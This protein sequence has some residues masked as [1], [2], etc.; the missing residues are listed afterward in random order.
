MF[1]NGTN[2]LLTKDET[3]TPSW[4][5]ELPAGCDDPGQAKELYHD[6]RSWVAELRGRTEP[7]AYPLRTLMNVAN[8]VIYSVINTHGVPAD[9]R[10]DSKDWRVTP[11]DFLD[12]HQEVSVESS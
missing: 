8:V 7:P 9:L 11:T 5:V 2:T 12:I 6:A 4:E 10:I 3:P 1:K